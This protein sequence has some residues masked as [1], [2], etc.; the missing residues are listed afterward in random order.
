MDFTDDNHFVLD[1][2]GQLEQTADRYRTAL[3]AIIRHQQIVA[4]SMSVRSTV[5]TIAEKALA[6]D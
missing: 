5:T 2:C 6:D 1:L 3:K 4:G